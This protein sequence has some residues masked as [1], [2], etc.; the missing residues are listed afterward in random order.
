M[1]NKLTCREMLKK[2]VIEEHPEKYEELKDCEIF[3]L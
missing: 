2:K 3:T 1:R